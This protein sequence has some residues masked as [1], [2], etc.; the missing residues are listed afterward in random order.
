MNQPIFKHTT[1]NPPTVFQPVGHS[2]Q[3]VPIHKF[4]PTLNNYEMVD[5]RPIP[6]PNKMPNHPNFRGNQAQ[7]YIFPS[8]G[9]P[10]DQN[11]TLKL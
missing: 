6:I 5:S 7:S 8:Q 10:A 9:P 11:R 3:P 4:N 1:S 2:Y